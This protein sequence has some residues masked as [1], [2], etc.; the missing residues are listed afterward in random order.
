ICAAII[1]ASFRCPLV[2]AAVV[3]ATVLGTA[4]VSPSFIG[5][6]QLAP[7]APSQQLS[8]NSTIIS[9]PSAAS[10]ATDSFTSLSTA[11]D[12]ATTVSATP[13]IASQFTFLTQTSLLVAP[14]S[15]TPSPSLSLTN[16]D[17]ATST[18]SFTLLSSTAS[19]SAASLPSGMP[20]QIFPAEGIPPGT[21][22][23]GY[24][25]ISILFDPSLRW[26]WVTSHS[27]SATQLLAYTPIL[28][29]SALNITADQVLT[30]ALQVWKPA[31]YESTAD[32]DKLLT[33]YLA[34]IPSSM[35]DQ[36]AQEMLAKNSAFYTA[37]GAPYTQLAAHVD[38]SFP[39]S[40]AVPAAGGSNDPSAPGGG[41]VA[42]SDSSSSSKTREDVIIGVVSSLGAITLLVLAFLV[43]RALKQRRDLAHRRLSDAPQGADGF[44][45]AR[46][47]NQD[48]D[49]DSVGGQRRRSFYYAE[50]SLRDG[51]PVGQDQVVSDENGMRERRP[52]NANMI[53]TPILRD[54][55]MNW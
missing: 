44:V 34:W 37:A 33:T 10:S 16:P 2:S 39:V 15:S 12:N 40:G 42:A 50:D 25:F 14:T 46:P 38:A 35:V 30:Y 6:S 11:S 31:D 28:I 24:T 27:D 49:R 43:V 5:T 45:G 53:G 22:T 1:R 21:N 19:P 18:A 4:V 3:S 32:S 51:L 20:A 29:Q 41:S 9:F 55:T 8:K 54:N 47:E 52:V 26:S 23:N 36:L 13:T 7:D 48:F 17:Q